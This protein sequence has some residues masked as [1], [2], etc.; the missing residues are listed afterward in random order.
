MLADRPAIGRRGAFLRTLIFYIAGALGS[1]LTSTKPYAI[2]TLLV[3]R[4][5]QGVGESCTT[6]CTAVTRDAIPKKE[7]RLRVLTVISSLRLLGIATA[8]TVGG[9]IGAAY[10][11]RSVFGGLAVV[12]LLL[13]GL[14]LSLVPE[15]L[16]SE[17]KDLLRSDSFGPVLERLWR[18]PDPDFG[19]ARGSLCAIVFGSSA[20]LCFFSD[21]SPILQEHFGVSVSVTALWIGTDSLIYVIVNAIMFCLLGV[22][23]GAKWLQPLRVLKF[24]L[25]VRCI[26][27]I[28]SLLCA[29]GPSFLRE[30]WIFLFL[31]SWIFGISMASGYGAASTLFVQPYPDAAGKAASVILITRTAIGTG[32]SQLSTDVTTAF[33]VRGYFIY[34]GCVSLLAQLAWLFLPRDDNPSSQGFIRSHK[35]E[36]PDLP[37]ELRENLLLAPSDDDLLS[38]VSGSSVVTNDDVP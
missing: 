4:M 31:N 35:S 38:S 34:F 6:I 8:P 17:E 36:F 10:G 2:F 33:G 9:L 37:E 14:L 20:L 28:T 13:L 26:A 32:L 1:Y 15:T 25:C 7:D 23:K 18:D 27:S 24:A 5:I 11:W 29:F 3:S 22:F 16:R 30:N 19:A 12:A 21:I